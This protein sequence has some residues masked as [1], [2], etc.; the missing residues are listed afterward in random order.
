ME[1]DL[2]KFAMYTMA[3]L[4]ELLNAINGIVGY[5]GMQ[6]TLLNF[7]DDYS[8]AEAVKGEEGKAEEAE[9]RKH[10]GH[11]FSCEYSLKDRLVDA[12]VKN[13]IHDRRKRKRPC[14]RN[15]SLLG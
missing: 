7:H 1:T 9:I 6:A 10:V 4:K 5:E 3:P 2:R 8:M 13:D 14:K 12:F 11:V 15:G